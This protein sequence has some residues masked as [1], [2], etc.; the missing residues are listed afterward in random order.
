MDPLSNPTRPGHAEYTEL[1]AT[2]TNTDEPFDAGL[3]DIAEV[4]W[5]LAGR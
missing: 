4:N 3:L 1:V 5:A 2:T